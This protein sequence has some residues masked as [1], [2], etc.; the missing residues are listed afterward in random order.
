[1]DTVQIEI[2]DKLEHG[3]DT[4]HIYQMFSTFV[5]TI[6]SQSEQ[7]LEMQENAERTDLLIE[8][9]TQSVR[10]MEMNIQGFVSLPAIEDDGTLR[11]SRGPSISGSRRPSVQHYVLEQQQD[12]I[13]NAVQSIPKP[14]STSTSPRLR[15]NEWEDSPEQTPPPTDEVSGTST[16]TTEPIPAPRKGSTP[17]ITQEKPRPRRDSGRIKAPS[18]KFKK[19]RI[20][21][22][23]SMKLKEVDESALDSDDTSAT[24]E[25]NLNKE[26]VPI[27]EHLPVP[28]PDKEEIDVPKKDNVV[29]DNKNEPHED[30]VIEHDAASTNEVK[31]E[32]TQEREQATELES[33]DSRESPRLRSNS[34]KEADISQGKEQEREETKTE[35]AETEREETKIEREETKNE[36]EETK[37]GR[38]ETK[39]E[40]EETKSEREETK[41]EREETKNGR[42]ETKTEREETK[43]E[44]DPTS[45][46]QEVP[47]ILS[48]ASRVGSKRPSLSVPLSHRSGKYE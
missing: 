6:K 9:M 46:K 7:I 25:E 34:E 17:T 19:R 5:D 13:E 27:E 48:N 12:L 14:T 45:H 44:R 11:A 10:N 30:P 15:P 47:S 42:E 20:I 39:S 40:R 32:P 2:A 26:T 4:R 33:E 38:E 29:P 21:R 28:V 43:K 37:S 35:R 1:M 41:T 36:R 8:N 18:W 24:Q 22:Q 23:V 3:F 16:S 31:Q